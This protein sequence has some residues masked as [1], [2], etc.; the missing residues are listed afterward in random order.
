MTPARRLPVMMVL[1]SAV[2]WASSFT[3]IKVGL[4][5]LDP[6]SFVLLRFAAAAAILLGI[7][8]ARGQWSRFCRYMGDK[9]VLCLGITLAASYG[10]QFVGQ[11]Q[12]TAAK[13]VIIV[14]SSTILVAPLSY[15]LL[16]EAMGRRKLLS[17]ALGIIGVF[18]I[19]IGRGGGSAQAGTLRGDLLMSGSAVAYSFYVVL[20]RMA[21]SRRPYSEAPMMAGVFVW[22][23]PIFLAMGLPV[24]ARGVDVDRAA[25]AA[26]GYLAVFCSILPF[27]IWTAAMKYIG[28]LT[29]AIVLLAELVFGVV[30]AVLLLGET[31]SGAVLAGCALIA[32]AIVIVGVRS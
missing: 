30:I 23:L 18:L 8:A 17:L 16:K 3:V 21:V 14:N 1:I 7:V 2:L 19:T 24:I 20:T 28:A 29:S 4:G 31:V 32:A 11:T 22:S 9:Y 27:I 5:H 6:Y 13:A 25:W 12:T 26:I 15:F 10:F